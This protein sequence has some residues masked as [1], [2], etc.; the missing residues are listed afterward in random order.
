M[1]SLI[2]FGTDFSKF[3]EAECLIGVPAL[4][5]RTNVLPCTFK[6]MVEPN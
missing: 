4:L 2:E 6:E 5:H 3:I 1:S